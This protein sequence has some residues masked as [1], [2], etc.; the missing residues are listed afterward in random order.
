MIYIGATR[1]SI[2]IG[3]FKVTLLFQLLFLLLPSWSGSPLW[4]VINHDQYIGLIVQ[5]SSFIF[6]LSSILFIFWGS[7][8][9]RKLFYLLLAIVFIFV[10]SLLVTGFHSGLL[11]V[12]GIPLSYLCL[13][14]IIR[15]YSC[16]HGL[17]LLSLY[18]M[19][20]WCVLPILCLPLVSSSEKVLFFTAEDGSLTTF[21]GFALHRNF[22][23]MVVGMVII[24]LLKL[25]LNK[26]FKLSS[27][28]ILLIGVF[29]CSSRS[30]IVSV[31]V[32]LS[33][34]YIFAEKSLFLKHLPFI[35][36]G[37]VILCIAYSL[38][39]QYSLRT[40][41]DN[42]AR[43]ELYQ[44]F[45]SMISEHPIWGYGYPVKYYSIR[46]NFV[47]GSPAHNF[48]VQLWADY[49]LIVL[50]S[51]LFL[52]FFVYKKMGRY[53]RMFLM[54]VMVW[55]LFQPYFGFGIPSSQVTV[56]ILLG[57]LMDNYNLK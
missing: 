27:F 25:K 17:L 19:L 45:F 22:Y 3:I 54:Y 10:L 36:L 32:V 55:G 30:A 52:L 38:Y 5:G 53:S 11:A 12:V 26:L 50:L 29:I 39:S 2:L 51:F 23:G 49:G 40:G 15:R 18:I 34:D 43:N 47:A 48:I 44:G 24:L 46:P 56:P 28:M 4:N 42:D 16:S 33:I 14:D 37:V 7:G 20:I 41:S 1:R 21:T 31:V 35:I 8:F 57:Y 6:L 13:F 9:N